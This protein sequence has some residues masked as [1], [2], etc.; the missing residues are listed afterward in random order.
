MNK[1]TIETL[2]AETLKDN[3]KAYSEL[4]VIYKKKIS[5]FILNKYGYCNEREDDVSDI[6]IKIFEN[7]NKY[8]S[9]KGKFDTWVNM[10]SKNY[11]IDKSKKKKPLYV[12]FTSSTFNSDDI[13]N[14][15]NEI[16]NMFDM[17]EPESNDLSPYES[18]ETTD[19]LD[20]ISK[21]IGI[22][23][24]KI[25]SMKYKDGYSYNEIAK[26]FKSNE[27]KISNKINNSKTKIKGGYSYDEITKRF[28]SE[29]NNKR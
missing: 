28:K 15:D 25:L 7:L 10:I 4:Y 29:V 18:L 26:K 22:E 17:T 12:S 23:N 27:S 20:F 24:F 21:K 14:E 8:D 5:L 16:S 13:S 2:I 1:T 11:M 6:L 3:K 19:A 9:E